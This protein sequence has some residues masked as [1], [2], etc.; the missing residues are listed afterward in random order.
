ML[1]TH[2]KG[3][4]HDYAIETAYTGNK[5]GVLILHVGSTVDQVPVQIFGDPV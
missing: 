4:P 1:L 2:G 3:T 5:H